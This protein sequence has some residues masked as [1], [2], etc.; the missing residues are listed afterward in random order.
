[1][2]EDGSRRYAEA[3]LKDAHRTSRKFE[4]PTTRCR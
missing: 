1:V 2:K 4:H 3:G